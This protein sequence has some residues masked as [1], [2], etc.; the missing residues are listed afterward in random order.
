MKR[1][2]FDD[3]PKAMEAAAVAIARTKMAGGPR[4]PFFKRRYLDA[5]FNGSLFFWDTAM[6][7]AWAKY[8]SKDLPILGALDNFYKVQDT[9]GFICRQYHP[10][11]QAAF[12]KTHPISVAPPILT[13]AEWECFG[14]TQ[15]RRRL[16]RVYP[17]LVRFHRF[18]E[19]TYR[20]DEGLYWSDA[21]GS[22]MDNLP[23]APHGWKDDGKGVKLNIKRC[24][25]S[26][27]KW[28]A[29]VAAAPDM[30]DTLCWN[31]QGRSVDLSAQTALDASHLG[32][33]AET[34]GLAA[35]AEAWRRERDNINEAINRH[36]WSAKASFYFDLGYGRRITRRHIGMFWTL[37][38][39][40]AA[41][42]AQRR[43]MI[44]ALKDPARFGRPVPVPSLAADEPEYSA[45]GSYWQGGVWPPTSYMVLRGLQAQGEDAFARKLAHRFYRAVQIVYRHT[46]TFWE[47]Y[48]PEFPAYGLPSRPDFCGWTGL[49][50]V[51]IRREFL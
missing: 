37:W 23:R 32:A 33:V 4:A 27:R 28:L 39:G 7:A 20:G 29:S 6:I 15:D 5:A 17:A 24:H 40:A 46:G 45:W 8:Y 2:P 13:W 34:L 42:T 10:D 1:P 51:A 12:V 31:R 44:R 19:K 50:P 38:S 11:G 16:Q 9:D 47:N 48:A 3:S 49:V 22:G 26:V 41:D 21:H 14:Q 36:C 30:N 43:A 35:E 18:M 25:P